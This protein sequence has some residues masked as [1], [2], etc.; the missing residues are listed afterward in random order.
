M[1]QQKK[2]I[3]H[4]GNKQH[5]EK[6][7]TSACFRNRSFEKSYGNVKT[8]ILFKNNVQQMTQKSLKTYWSLLKLFL[9]NKTI[10]ITPR[11]FHEDKLVTDF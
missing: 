10:P 5:I 8:K 6:I 1:V 4:T 2:K 3:S 9:N 11:L 7:K